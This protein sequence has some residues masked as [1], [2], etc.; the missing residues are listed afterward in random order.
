MAR[1][2]SNSLDIVLR[3]A[4][5]GSEVRDAEL[6]S[7]ETLLDTTGSLEELRWQLVEMLRAGHCDLES[8]ALQSYLRNSVA[9]Q[10]AIDQPKYSGFKQVLKD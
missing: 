10:I 2:A 1:V 4:S 3:E 5:L 6:N 7:L 8:T 9:N